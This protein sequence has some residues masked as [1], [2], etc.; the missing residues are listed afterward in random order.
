MGDQG[1]VLIKEKDPAKHRAFE[2][3]LFTN[4]N[5][6]IDNDNEVGAKE[7]GKVGRG[8][9]EGLSVT[10]TSVTLKVIRRQT[11]SLPLLNAQHPIRLVLSS[12]Y[13]WNDN[14]LGVPGPW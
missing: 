9:G 3:K 8:V 13:W 14:G 10:A 1:S 4:P 2:V 7:M 6:V 12:Y 11:A 5:G